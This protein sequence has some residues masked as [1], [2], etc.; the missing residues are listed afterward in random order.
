M[1]AEVWDYVFMD[2]Q[3]PSGSG[4]SSDTLAAMRREF[5]FWYPWDLRVRANPHTSAQSGY[6]YCTGYRLQSCLSPVVHGALISTAC[7]H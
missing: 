1:T 7:M 6:L 2:G 5:E 4:I 3:M